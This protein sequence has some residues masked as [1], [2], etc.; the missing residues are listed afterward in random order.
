MWSEVH[1][2]QVHLLPWFSQASKY[3]KLMDH[4]IMYT[5]LDQQTRPLTN[6]R[7]GSEKFLDHYCK[8]TQAQIQP[9]YKWSLMETLFW[10]V[11]LGEVGLQLKTLLFRSGKPSKETSLRNETPSLIGEW[12]CILGY[13]WEP[14]L[15]SG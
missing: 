8:W 1:L 2:W 6:E 9:E 4:Y 5:P 14:S 15:V 7:F 13:P 3:F 11:F 10:L 12:L